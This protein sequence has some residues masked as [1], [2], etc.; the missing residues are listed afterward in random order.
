MDV[1][2]LRFEL[3]G[4]YYTSRFYSILLSLSLSVSLTLVCIPES[5][6]IVNLFLKHFNR[7]Y[8]IDGLFL[9]TIRGQATPQQLSHWIQ[10]GALA[11]NGLVGCF[12]MT[13]LGH[14]STLELFHCVLIFKGS[15]VA[16]LETTATFDEASDEFIIHTPTLTA[17]KW[18]IGGAAQTATHS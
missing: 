14:V 3:L 5:A 6:F 2:K 10:K 15:N 4:Y 9:S 7:S 11:L 18:W 1:L 8:M 16:G 17:T 12:A 13:E